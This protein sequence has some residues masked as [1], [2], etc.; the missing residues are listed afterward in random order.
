MTA[1]TGLPGG[2]GWSARALVAVLTTAVL[3]GC[4]VPQDD[5]PRALAPGEAPYASPR[6][7]PVADPEGRGRVP[8]HFVQEGSVVLTPRPVEGEVSTVELLD[9]LFGGPAPEEREAGLLSVIPSTVTVEDVEMSGDIAVVTLGGPESEVLRLQQLAYAQIVA[10]LTPSRAAGVRF[11]LG[12][13]D[14][15]VPRGDGSLTTAP[16]SRDDYAALLAPPAP[17]APPPSA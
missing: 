7:S 5:A 9:L 1:G 17:V 14:L 3:S 11:R 12:S 10:T 8:L 4:G 13:S 16:L 15:R 6:T 2:T